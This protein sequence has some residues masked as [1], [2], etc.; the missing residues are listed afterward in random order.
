MRS[1]WGR[2]YRFPRSRGVA[3]GSQSRTG[4][5]AGF[6]GRLERSCGAGVP[7]IPRSDKCGS[8]SRASA[9]PSSERQID[10]N[11][12]DTMVSNRAN[13]RWR[14]VH[15]QGSSRKP[16]VESPPPRRRASR[17]THTLTP[18]I[19]ASMSTRFWGG[20]G[21]SSRVRRPLS[22]ACCWLVLFAL[23]LGVC[24]A[25]VHAAE[26]PTDG[27]VIGTPQHGHQGHGQGMCDDPDCCAAV[28]QTKSKTA[29]MT[30]LVPNPTVVACAT[31]PRT[32]SARAGRCKAL[33]SPPLGSA[34]PMT[35]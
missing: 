5:G 20:H 16:A 15:V 31:D 1:L 23:G 29:R 12:L 19:L 13:R 22:S 32:M 33:P 35:L 8:P 30:A 18:H 9:K 24:P 14:K 26:A 10:S 17:L 27:V 25:L 21:A 7:V 4:P 3:D 34:L 2:G 6:R 11:G 28:L